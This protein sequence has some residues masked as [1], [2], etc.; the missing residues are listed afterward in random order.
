MIFIRFTTSL[1][2]WVFWGGMDADAILKETKDGPGFGRDDNVPR[3]EINVEEVQMH[4]FENFEARLKALEQ[5]KIKTCRFGE[6]P[7]KP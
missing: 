2:I 6:V 4:G 1:G 5:G 7:A 3:A